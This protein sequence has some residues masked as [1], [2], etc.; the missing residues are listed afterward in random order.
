MTYATVQDVAV[1]LG[2]DPSSI[3]PTE[4]SQWQQWLERVERSITLRFSRVGL[5]LSVQV[6]AN[7][8]PADAV[9]DVEVAVVVRKISNPEGIS[10]STVSVDDASVTKRH[11]GLKSGPLELLDWEL[12]LLLPK[13]QAEQWST[14]PGFEP[15]RRGLDMWF[16]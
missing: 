6:A 3:T 10:S 9:A 16:Q 8:P 1:D 4:T 12:D 14:R 13:G 7:D 15:D 11:E 2:R 5:D